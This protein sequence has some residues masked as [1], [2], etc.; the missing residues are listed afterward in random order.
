MYEYYDNPNQKGPWSTS[1]FWDYLKLLDLSFKLK[2]RKYF[3]VYLYIYKQ[4]L[5]CH[6]YLNL[7]STVDY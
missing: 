2:F 1:E 7:F 3:P 4:S 5:I 6:W